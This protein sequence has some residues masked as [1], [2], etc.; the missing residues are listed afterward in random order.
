MKEQSTENLV[1]NR[2]VYEPPRFMRTDEAAKQLLAIMSGRS[3]G[4]GDDDVCSETPCI[5]CVRLGSQEQHNMIST[6][7][8]I[9]QRICLNIVF[10]FFANLI[11]YFPC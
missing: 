8:G 7:Q 2:K 3:E 9:H 10:Y 11:H 4:A 5:A 1:K 6:L